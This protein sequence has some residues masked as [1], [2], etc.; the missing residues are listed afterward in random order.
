MG[1]FVS[2]D[3]I[4][5]IFGLK[6]L[7]IKMSFLLNVSND[8]GSKP[9]EFSINDIEVL[10]DEK[11]QNWF[12]RKH[13]RKFLGLVYMHRSAAKLADK[14]QKTRTFLKAEG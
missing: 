8:A 13:V 7:Q 10:V 12:K 9:E 11:E 1:L 3:R 6:Q 14:D 2:G 4:Q 5:K